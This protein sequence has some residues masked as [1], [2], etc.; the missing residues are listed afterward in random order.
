MKNLKIPS[1]SYLSKTVLSENAFILPHSASYIKYNFIKESYSELRLW[2][3]LCL[4]ISF[5]GPL[6]FCLSLSQ[7]VALSLAPSQQR[8][9]QA[10][11]YLRAVKS[12]LTCFMQRLRTTRS[13]TVHVYV[14]V[15]VRMCLCVFVIAVA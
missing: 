8:N 10:K 14:L 4:L 13:I 11:Y 12:Q 5:S 1:D 9:K 2:S 3:P 6:Y 7:V 15:C